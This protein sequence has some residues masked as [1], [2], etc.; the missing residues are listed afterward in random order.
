MIK[1]CK[2][3]CCCFSPLKYS[4]P[5]TNKMVSGSKWYG[6]TKPYEKIIIRAK[7]EGATPRISLLA[8]LFLSLPLPSHNGRPAAC[9]HFRLWQERRNNLSIVAPT[10]S[11]SVL[12]QSKAIPNT[13]NVWA[14]KSRSACPRFSWPESSRSFASSACPPWSG[15][16]APAAAHQ[17]TVFADRTPNLNSLI[18]TCDFETE[19][20]LMRGRQNGLAGCQ[21]LHI[22]LILLKLYI[23]ETILLTLNSLGKILRLLEEVRHSTSLLCLR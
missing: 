4:V 15:G 20:V 8:P 13:A 12:R 3:L 16:S 23:G 9:R 10:P 1:W 14:Q 18:I 7:I 19:I 17:E 6:I 5:K 2:V 11:N 21:L 22:F